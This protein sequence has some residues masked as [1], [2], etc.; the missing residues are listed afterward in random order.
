MSKIGEFDNIAT[1]IPTACIQALELGK[2]IINILI[3]TNEG[4]E[5]QRN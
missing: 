2:E 4:F 3:K 1:D 5:A